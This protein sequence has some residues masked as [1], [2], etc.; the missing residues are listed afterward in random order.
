MPRKAKGARLWLRPESAR[1]PSQWIIRDGRFWKSTGCG[2]DAYGEAER[3]LAEYIASKHDPAKS[4]RSLDQIP[5]ADVISLYLDDV[6]SE[7]TNPKK[8]IDRA[9]RLLAFFGECSLAEINKKKCKE[10]AVVRGNGSAR[11]ELQ[12]LSAAIGNAL[13]SGLFREIV[14]VWL[15]PAG[16][17]RNRFLER[18]EA[19]RLLWICWRTR[20]T[21]GAWITQRRPLRHLARFILIGLYTGSRSG[22][23]CGLSWDRTTHRGWVDLNRGLIYRKAQDTRETNKRQPPVPASPRLLAHLRR[24]SKIDGGEGPVVRFNGKAVLQ[25]DKAFAR[26][27][28]MA[29]LEDTIPYTLRHTC[30]SWLVQRGV[31]TFKVAEVLGTSEAMI[32]KHYGH[33]AP[34]HLREEVA[35]LTRK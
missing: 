19:A 25:I 28:G 35:M 20:E 23:I 29:G 26:A 12:D 2:P 6:V 21:Q 15:P 4:G 32:K 17:A 11:R 3:Q 13:E 8:G 34:K 24:W 27:T 16:K 33:L 1:E 31:S 18:D 9:A 5:V 14:K 30:A 10:Y 22:A 7:Q